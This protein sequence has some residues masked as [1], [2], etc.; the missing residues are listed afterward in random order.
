[1]RS[2]CLFIVLCCVACS[3]GPKQPP[4]GPPVASVGGSPI[5]Q[6]ELA[7]GI[8]TESWKFG[9]NLPEAK[10]QVLENLIKTKLLT[11]EAD[12]RGIKVEEEE[13]AAELE[14][15]RKQYQND[16]TL[17][18]TLQDRGLTLE[19]WKQKRKEE[20]LLKKFVQSFG[21]GIEFEEKELKQYF[22]THAEDFAAAEQIRV[23]QMVT[24]SREKAESLR[25]KL[26]EGGD[27]ADLA[28]NY[29]LSPDRS[30]GGDLGYFA[31]G[32][33]PPAFDQACFGLKPK[34][35]SPVT[36]TIYGYHIFQL[37]DRKPA[38]NISFEEAKPV[39]T[40][41]LQEQKGEERFGDWYRT[42]RETAQVKV[43]QKALADLL[44]DKG[45]PATDN[46]S[47]Q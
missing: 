17:E 39:L 37:L 14:F 34:E 11:Q 2:L 44:T 42:F 25:K 30:K 18:K 23:R 9:D 8:R 33:M 5:Y 47:E 46:G 26:T 1:M 16:A 22:K 20:L 4:K 35:I 12:K 28:R 41:I 13:V 31:R 15:F 6:D 24:D 27:F 40:K 29:S 21:E 19:Q 7:Q 43:D 36:Q 38:K 10:Q 45:L 32:T 3:G